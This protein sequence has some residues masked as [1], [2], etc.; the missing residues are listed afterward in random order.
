MMEWRVYWSIR[1]IEWRRRI[2]PLMR[3]VLRV[4]LRRTAPFLS[5]VSSILDNA[6]VERLW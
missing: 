1:S 2:E 4:R 5:L 6:A 3:G